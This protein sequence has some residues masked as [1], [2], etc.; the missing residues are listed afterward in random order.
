[1]GLISQWRS[2]QVGP[3]PVEMLQQAAKIIPVYQRESHLMLDEWMNQIDR[4]IYL[5]Q[6]MMLE[7]MEWEKKRYSEMRVMEEKVFA[8]SVKEVEEERMF[9]QQLKEM[10]I[11][12][13]KA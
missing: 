8:Q 4:D 11:K 1:M 9:A 7:K 2:A 6:R 13:E 10:K 3:V 5:S 12:D